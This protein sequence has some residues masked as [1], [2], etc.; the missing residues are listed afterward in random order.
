MPQIDSGD[1]ADDAYDIEPNFPP[2]ATEL[3]C[4][5]CGEL[6][7]GSERFW[8]QLHREP[9]GREVSKPICEVCRFI[10]D[11]ARPCHYCLKPVHHNLNG[12][13]YKITSTLLAHCHTTCF[14]K[15]RARKESL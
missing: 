13:I 8:E 4:H 5:I 3:G 2:P 7:E 9:D 15:L 10:A 1:P 14:E 11:V 12:A 6:P